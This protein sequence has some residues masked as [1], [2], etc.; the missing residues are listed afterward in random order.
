[1]ISPLSSLLCFG[2]VFSPLS[3]LSSRL[4]RPS[5]TVLYSKAFSYLESRTVKI[6]CRDEHRIRL[7]AYRDEERKKNN[8]SPKMSEFSRVASTHSPK[9]SRTTSC[10]TE[11]STDSLYNEVLLDLYGL[12]RNSSKYI[13]IAIAT[14]RL[15]RLPYTALLLIP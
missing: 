14:K 1:L 10:F 11:Q 9:F 8:C 2:T 4:Q 13:R 5:S 6:A 3:L 15:S 7:F 12:G